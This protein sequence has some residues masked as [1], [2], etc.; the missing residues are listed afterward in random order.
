V[1]RDNDKNYRLWRVIVCDQESSKNEEAKARYRAVENTTPMGCNAKKTNKQTN[2]YIELTEVYTF[3]PNTHLFSLF[4]RMSS[5]YIFNIGVQ[6]FI[7]SDHIQG[8]TQARTNA[9][10]HTRQESSGQGIG[11]SQR[12]IQAFCRGLIFNCKNIWCSVLLILWLI[13]PRFTLWETVPK[14]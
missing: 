5:V 14:S 7:A 4:H 2:I 9:R 11:P 12:P 6:N 1:V 13:L 8:R 3:S 10:K